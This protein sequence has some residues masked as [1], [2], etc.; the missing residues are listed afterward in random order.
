MKIKNRNLILQNKNILFLALGVGVF[1]LLVRVAMQFNSGEGWSGFDYLFAGAFL[2]SIG[3]AFELIRRKATT[4]EYRVAVG[5]TLAGI[6]L[7]IWINLAVGIIG[8]EDNPA[9]GMYLGVLA[10]LGLGSLLALL[11]PRGMARALFAAA[12]AHAIVAVVA[13]LLMPWG[14]DALKTLALN[15]FFVALW[16]SAGWLFRRSVAA[17]QQA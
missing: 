3:L 2:F 10:V 5:A 16:A 7:L 4:L 6:L 8:S 13:M 15:L 1:L 11:R 17:E 12:L 9:N 14:L